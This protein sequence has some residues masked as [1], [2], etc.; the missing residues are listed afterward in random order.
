[1]FT[2][3]HHFLIEFSSSTTVHGINYFGD[4]QRHWTERVF[5]IIV[6]VMSM[7]ACIFMVHETYEKW[8]NSPII[9]TQDDKLNALSEIPFPAVTVCPAAKIKD[10]WPPVNLTR[11]YNLL[12]KKAIEMFYDGVIPTLH[13]LEDFKF[14]P[15]ELK[16][17]NVTEEELWLQEAVSH[18]CPDFYKNKQDIWKQR[19]NS[20][21]VFKILQKHA[22]D[23][24]EVI[25]GQSFKSDFKKDFERV[26]TEEGVCYTFNGLTNFDIFKK[27]S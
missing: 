8:Q 3:V 2:K 11:T 27:N 6:F 26:F 16:A 23:S 4:R 1:M 24:R 13:A 17:M 18:I 5:W 19:L 21:V 7:S 25:L 12:Y 15:D 14:N 22:L 9:V 20:S 10:I